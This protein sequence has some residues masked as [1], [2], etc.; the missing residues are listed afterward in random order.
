MQ[1][2]LLFA[3][4]TGASLN[5]ALLGGAKLIL[6]NLNGADLRQ[7]NLS[8]TDL[9]MTQALATNFTG[10]TLTGACIED[11]AIN[12]ATCFQD[13]ICDYVYLRS[14]NQERCPK[15]GSFAPGGFT[16][17]FQQ[18]VSSIEIR[19]L[20]G[21]EW[22]AFLRSL[23]A[24]QTRWSNAAI[25]L[26]ALEAKDEGTFA[27]RLQGAAT[28]SEIEQFAIKQEFQRAYE[29]EL[30][31]IDATHQ[32]QPDLTTEQ[33]VRH[34]RQSASLIA[35]VRREATV[36]I[37]AMDKAAASPQ[38]TLDPELERPGFE[39]PETEHPEAEHS[40]VEHLASDPPDPDLSD[41]PLLEVDLLGA[42]LS[43][44]AESSEQRAASKPLSSAEAARL[45]TPPP[46]SDRPNGTDAVQ[47]SRSQSE[48]TPVVWDDA[49]ALLKDIHQSIQ[50]A[51]LPDTIKTA[52][53]DY[54]R[55][56]Q[57]ETQK[58]NPNR[59]RVRV[60]LEGTLETLAEDESGIGAD[61]NL[62]EQVTPLLVKIAGW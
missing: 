14:D 42:A 51:T 37:G 8:Q 54:L 2:S 53:M 59:D 36:S 38:P 34:R 21:I 43:S 35:I 9:S 39:R 4:L 1:A 18:T 41:V 27:I 10:A 30:Q 57:Q 33:I 62:W 52:A 15:D 48:K 7:A 12:H 19:F 31:A 45:T 40:E 32:S 60:N 23:Q 13:A 3:N 16:K 47:Q 25:A 56:A 26:Q 20:E 46:Q 17:R 6:A 5:H 28:V 50:A 58:A 49:I 24:I 44:N 55:A 11:W 22:S 29:Q 61:L